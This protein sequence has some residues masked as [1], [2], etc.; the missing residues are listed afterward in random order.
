MEVTMMGRSLGDITFN[1]MAALFTLRDT[2]IP[3]DKVMSEVGIEQGFA[4]LD[5][6]CGPGGYVL[7]T[8]DLVGPS[9][10]Y[11]ALDRNPLAIRKVERL[12]ASK[13]LANVETIQSDCATGLPDASVDIVLLYDIF[14]M[15]EDADGVLRELWRVL[16]PDGTLSVSDHHLKED[17]IVSG[18]TSGGLFRMTS[19]GKKTCSFAK[20]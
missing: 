7:P 9:G 13:G 19:K 14:H 6:G 8:M 1:G 2:L 20:A 17:A 12:A 16:K 15:L 3:R 11:Y 18:M 4:V 10:K 5:Y